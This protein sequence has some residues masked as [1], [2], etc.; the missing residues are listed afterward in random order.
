VFHPILP[1]ATNPRTAPCRIV[2]AQVLISC[3]EQQAVPLF[4]EQLCRSIPRIASQGRPRAQLAAEAIA[5][6]KPSAESARYGR[7]EIDGTLDLLRRTVSHQVREL[8]SL[9]AISTLKQ[10]DSP[11]RHDR[12]HSTP[13][14]G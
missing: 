12:K 8:G 4:H 14:P 10:A 3:T 5:K 2:Y 13:E 6:P 11:I 1:F 9:P 7:K